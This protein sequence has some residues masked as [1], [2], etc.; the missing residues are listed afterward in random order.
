M[1]IKI[2]ELKNEEG[3]VHLSITPAEGEQTERQNY[4]SAI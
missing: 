2:L 4:S 1:S 3:T